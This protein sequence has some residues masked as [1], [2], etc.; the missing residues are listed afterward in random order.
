MLRTPNVV[1]FFTV[2]LTFGTAGTWDSTL[3]A[4]I[5]MPDA[6]ETWPAIEPV[7]TWE[8]HDETNSPYSTS[9]R[10]TEL[11]ALPKGFTTVKD[12]VTAR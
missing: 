12:S 1:V 2:T 8:L 4:P 3:D 6:P 5:E 7:W 11:L 10:R 9:S